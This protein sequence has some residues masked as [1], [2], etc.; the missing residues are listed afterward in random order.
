MAFNSLQLTAD[1]Q[2]ALGELKSSIRRPSYHPK[3]GGTAA[4]D[5]IYDNLDSDPQ[6]PDEPSP[7]R[8]AARRRLI[9]A[10]LPDAGGEAAR[11]FSR[12]SEFCQ[13]HQQEGQPAKQPLLGHVADLG[14]L[15]DWLQAQG[16]GLSRQETL[17]G[18]RDLVRLPG[19]AA[20]RLAEQRK[21]LGAGTLARYQMWSVQ[22][23][24][25]AESFAE[26]AAKRR[27]VV[28]RLGLGHFEDP[29]IE[30]V[31]WMH[32]LGPVVAHRPTC[33]DAGLTFPWRRPT[34][35]TEPLDGSGSAAGLP[36]VVH[37][38][39]EAASLTAPISEVGP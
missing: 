23:A 9:V 37:A 14:K 7:G 16:S 10:L 22:A 33:W 24:D 29:R 30:L 28:N 1:E 35:R 31:Y 32:D 36:E 27:E 3:P 38:P 15:A 19:E 25:G 13:A 2:R 6:V 20:E 39:I 12:A 21:T 17:D 34:G 8:P 18:L 11:Y 4:P 26:L 5:Q